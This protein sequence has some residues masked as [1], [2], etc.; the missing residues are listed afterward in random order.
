MASQVA[1]IRCPDYQ[2]ERV[3]EALSQALE[4]LGG[5]GHFVRPGQRVLIKPNL[6]SAKPPDLAVTTHPTVVKAAIQLVREAG[7]VPLVGDSPAVGSLYRVAERAGILKVIQETGARLEPFEESVEVAP[8]PGSIFK[9]L[10]VAREAI[11]ADVILNVPKLKTHS[12]MLLTLGVK[13]LFGCVVGKRKAQ[14]HLM[15][16]VER[17]AFATMLVELYQVLKPTLTIVDGVV[18]MEGDG[19]GNG[20][21]RAL[22]LIFAGADAVALDRVISEVLRIK[23]D[24]LPTTRA[25]QGKGL[26]ETDITCI[27]ILGERLDGVA[28]A[29]FRLPQ[30]IEA[31]HG[32]TLLRGFL[33]E[34]LTAKPREDHSKCT[35]CRVCAE[36]CPPQVIFP[37]DGR[38]RF[39]YDRCIRCFCC[40]EVCPE[41][42]ME[43]RQGW[44]LRLLEMGSR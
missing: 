39:D 19:P 33:K 36:A 25:A 20:N 2:E 32:P 22:G 27:E 15:A 16:G 7:G 11:E 29:G 23:P 10:E 41:G 6:L 26:G 28:V 34:A 40:L 42:A 8:L 4:L 1:I 43:I 3:H 44:L 12:Q 38:L 24:S 14:W 31:E 21:P 9:K 35:L 17:D 13:N 37:G 18:G 30:L 5:I